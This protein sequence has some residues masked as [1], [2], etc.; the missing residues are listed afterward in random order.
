MKFINAFVRLFQSR[1][2]NQALAK[3]TK[4]FRVSTVWVVQ[5]AVMLNQAFFS[6]WYF[7][8][9]QGRTAWSQVT[10]T[11][12][13]Y[14]SGVEVV[15]FLIYLCNTWTC[16]LLRVK[17][18]NSRKKHIRKTLK[19]N[20]VRRVLVQESKVSWATPLSRLHVLLA[21][22]A[23]LKSLPHVN[24][25][26]LSPPRSQY[27]LNWTNDIGDINCLCRTSGRYYAKV[28]FASFQERQQ[29]V[30]NY[31]IE[32]QKKLE[33]KPINEEETAQQNQQVVFVEPSGKN[34]SVLIVWVSLFAGYV[35][36]YVRSY[37]PDRISD[38]NIHHYDLQA[39][40]SIHLYSLA[41]VRRWRIT[42]LTVEP[43]RWLDN[44]RFC[45]SDGQR[46]IPRQVSPHCI[47]STPVSK[48][49][50]SL[51]L[52]DAVVPFINSHCHFWD[53]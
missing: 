15:K 8:S 18:T 41:D 5:P 49:L 32:R 53:I 50:K 51:P 19:T 52:A 20:N 27:Q 12:S 6:F 31:A 36:N 4:M 26:S 33:L 23:F 17:T 25:S 35:S 43:N 37:D 1:A 9:G 14:F 38:D 48:L 46:G 24:A 28:V 44:G 29:M 34:W 22:L 11:R 39:S 42:L 47:Y 10:V 45:F 30:N 3:S 13:P 40:G 16:S 21:V 2:R 7:Y